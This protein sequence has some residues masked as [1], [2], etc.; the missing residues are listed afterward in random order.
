MGNVYSQTLWRVID[1]PTAN[2]FIEGPSPPD[3]YV[4]LIRRIS[5]WNINAEEPQQGLYLG[6]LGVDSAP[7]YYANFQDVVGLRGQEL[8]EKETRRVL[9]EALPLFAFDRDGGWSWEVTGWA[10]VLP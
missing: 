3:G 8:Y 1:N 4:W 9:S 2:E 10:L 6:A 7:I 5:V